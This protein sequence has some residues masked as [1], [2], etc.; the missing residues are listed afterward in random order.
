MTASTKPYSNISA[1][2]KN[3]GQAYLLAKRDGYLDEICGHFS[4]PD[5]KNRIW[6]D[7]AIKK[8]VSEYKDI[9]TFK[10]ENPSLYVYLSKLGKLLEF[11]G[12]LVRPSNKKYTE[13]EVALKLKEHTTIS[14]LG[15]IDKTLYNYT[16]ANFRHLLENITK[17]KRV[18]TYD[19]CADVAHKY[20]NFSDFYAS[21]N[22]IY[23]SALRA[24]WLAKITEH[25]SRKIHSKPEKSLVSFLESLTIVD[26]QKK[27]KREGKRYYKTDAFLPEHNTVIELDGLY[28]HSDGVVDKY[29]D[30]KT[31]LYNRRSFFEER[32][33]RFI[34]IFG[35]EWEYKHEIVKSMI[36][37]KLGLVQTRL[38]ARKMTLKE[39]NNT[40]AQHF[41]LEN[42]LMGEYKAA[43]HF[44]LYQ[45]G[46]LYSLIGFKKRGEGLEITR[47]C[48][49][50]NTI[51]IG[52]LSK[53]ISFIKSQIGDVE[54][55]SFVD[56][57]YG[58]GDSLKKIGFI[59][60]KTSIGWKW[61][62]RKKTYNRLSCR[63]NMDDRKLPQEAYSKELGW[64][65]IYDAGQSL[66]LLKP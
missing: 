13:D 66:F 46:V 55:Y 12:G 34:S 49:K 39:T 59:E 26:K 40:E 30:I 4:R 22:S 27:F 57:R 45:N 17:T 18:L 33:I 9:R 43:K 16:L 11:T 25:M 52:G 38:Y 36:R 31:K 54:I 3:N 6:T 41:L 21:E 65:K 56:R 48:N 64:H 15:K 37:A 42:H 58:N 44:G 19:F 53:L 5:Y 61:T 28:W 7:E 50:L 63:A 10:K 2:I 47:F 32:G 8:K 20:S 29:S 62:D 24:G 14:E 1:W 51:V 23:L 60:I 35:D